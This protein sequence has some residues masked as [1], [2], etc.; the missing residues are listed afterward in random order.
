[1]KNIKNNNE[2]NYL[3][4]TTLRIKNIITLSNI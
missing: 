2:N 1:M 3:T 4:K